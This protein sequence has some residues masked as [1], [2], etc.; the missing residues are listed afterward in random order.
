MTPLEG[1]HFQGSP[2]GLGSWL[3]KVPENFYKQNWK[4]SYGC[5]HT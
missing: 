2:E 1:V 4:Y 5:Q 3:D